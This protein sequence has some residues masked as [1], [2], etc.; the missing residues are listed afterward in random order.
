[1]RPREMGHTLLGA[2]LDPAV[3]ARRS[4]APSGRQIADQGAGRGVD[5][6]VFCEWRPDLLRPDV[7]DR[8]AARKWVQSAPIAG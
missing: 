3:L 7:G 5:G 4:A 6:R 8:Q 2:D 1:M